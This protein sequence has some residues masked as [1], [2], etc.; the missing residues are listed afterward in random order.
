M[1]Y[2]EWLTVWLDSYIKP[3]SKHNTYCCYNNLINN[4]IIPR[5]GEMELDSLT[6][7][8]L[9]RFSNELA[10]CGNSK[11][12]EGLSSSS[13]NLVITV[14]QRSLETAYRL[15]YINSYEADKIKRPKMR[16]RRIECFTL[17]EQKQ[18]EYAA[19]SH[20]KSKMRGI[21]LC[22]YTGL[23][24]G[25]LLALEWSD[26]DLDRL[27][28][29]VNKS[30]TDGRG[31]DGKYIRIVGAPK[32]DTSIRTV[33]IAAQLSELIRQMKATSTS[34][35][36]VGDAT[37]SVRSYQRSFELLLKKLDIPHRGFHS[38]RHTFATRA[39]ECGI[40]VRTLSE[41]LGHKN[42]SVTL[43]RYA[44]S[45]LEHKKTMIDKLGELL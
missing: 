10:A 38:L 27:E 12:G 18:I 39:L 29:S 8:A 34:S 3:L 19:L 28:I 42:P 32:T 2:M 30:C 13:V 9:Q 17:S 41:L 5:L 40:D 7:L 16:E 37:L 33:P 25:E 26:V 15:G 35:Y 44:H 21:V 36:V 14:L 1:K 6:P 4:H 22:L 31:E 43:A 20:R 45:M 11:T 23:R 24:I